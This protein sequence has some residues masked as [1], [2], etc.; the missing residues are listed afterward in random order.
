MDPLS[1]GSGEARSSEP[2]FLA[3]GRILRPHGLRGEVRVE[4]HTDSP[5]PL[6]HLLSR[7]TGI[8]QDDFTPRVHVSDDG[9]TSWSPLS[10]QDELPGSTCQWI[11]EAD[12]PGLTLELFRQR[13]RK[14]G[15]IS[16]TRKTRG[17]DIDAACG[18]LVG[19]VQDRS[20]RQLRNMRAGVNR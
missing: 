16:I 11:P 1:Q 12:E 13:L 18:Q 15:I 20:K 5:E 14:A 6:P 2:R 4:I 3:V 19:K 17:D 8:D 10:L 9:G 7:K